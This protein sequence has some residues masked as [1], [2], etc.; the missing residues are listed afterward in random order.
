MSCRFVLR[1]ATFF[2]LGLIHVAAGHAASVVDQVPKDAL[3]FVAVHN[4]ALA[5]A[6]LGNAFAALKFPIPAPLAVIKAAS[7]I[8]AGLD[9][10]RDTLVVLLPADDQSRPFH[11]ALWLPVKDYGAFVRSLDGDAERRTAAVT[12]AGE[13]LLVAQYKDWAVVMDPDQLRRL[14]QLES[15]AAS[16]TSTAAK[17]ASFVDAHDVTVVA[18]RGGFQLLMAA[19]APAPASDAAAKT[20]PPAGGL[21]NPFGGKNPAASSL[22]VMAAAFNSARELLESVPEM[23]RLTSEA[24]GIGCGLRFDEAGNAKATF[25]AVLPPDA[26]ASATATTAGRTQHSSAPCLYDGNEFVM[27]GAGAASPPWTV[28][29]VAPYV[30]QVGSELANDYGAKVDD[31]SLTAFR[32]LVEPAVGQVQAISLLTRP[33]GDNE[34]VYSNSFL[35][36]RVASGDEFVKQAKAVVDAWNTMLAKAEGGVGLV[37]EEKAISVAGQ[38]GTEYSIDMA[39]AVGA[40]QLPE[41][42]QSMEKLFGPGGRFRLQL[43]KVDDSTVL[44]AIATEEQLARPIQ[45]LQSAESA[46]AESDAKL[47]MVTALLSD[48]SDWKLYIS[49]D[50][51][52]RWMKRQMEAVV[53]PVFGGPVVRPFPASPPIGAAGGATGSAMWAE[54]AVPADTLRGIGEFLHQ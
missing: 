22:A 7:G 5:D 49:I 3:G 10:D 12:I 42:R 39:K 34:S 29:M 52:N 51:Y 50:G 21:E 6:K 54:V 4:L 2:L 1:I 43:L 28:S 41:A 16:S 14:E 25:R 8:G 38:D 35:A 15:E 53:G 11:L 26:G 44:M 19:A 46:G 31:A 24:V 45:V 20:P 9:T 33:G 23:K 30:Q 27:N 36:V 47:P 17:W 13:D 18:L 48:D 40:P 32:S 37:F